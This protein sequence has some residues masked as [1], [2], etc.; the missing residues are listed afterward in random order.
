MEN[1][2]TDDEKKT[3]KAKRRKKKWRKDMT[4]KTGERVE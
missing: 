1:G 4:N 3:R 2:K